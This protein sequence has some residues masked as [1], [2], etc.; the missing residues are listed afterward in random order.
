MYNMLPGSNEPVLKEINVLL[1]IIL[2]LLIAIGIK[3]FFF[4]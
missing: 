2:G 4:L 1:L 3:V